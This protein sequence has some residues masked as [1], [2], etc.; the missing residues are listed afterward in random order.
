MEKPDHR[1]DIMI[2]GAGSW[3]T[4]LSVVLAEKGH[5]IYLWVR[6]KQTLEDIKREGKNKKYTQDLLL[7][8]N[9][10]LFNSTKEI[11]ACPDIVIFAVP[12]H[13][14]R[15]VIET[16]YQFLSAIKK[17]RAVVNVAKGLETGTNLRLS[18][19]MAQTLPVHLSEKI[20]VLSGPNISSEIARKLPSVSAICS[21]NHQLLKWLQEFL[22][23][24]YFRVYTN[25]DM[26]GVEIG[27]AVKN[28]IA[29]AAGI[30]DGLGYG[31]NTK[32]SLVT[33]GLHEITRFGLKL[34]AKAQTFAGISGM[35]DLITTCFNQNSRN[36]CPKK[37]I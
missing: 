7:P 35:G 14:L 28:I 12:S 32:A 4:T 37:W 27:G 21:K 36:S 1:L 33:R 17:P 5:N 26:V 3:G 34:G 23:T 25:R 20:A 10:F 31:T 13:A 9:I 11:D 18:E 15:G 19:V 29:I 22:S 6:S 2:I 30:S 8:P 24:D 16:F